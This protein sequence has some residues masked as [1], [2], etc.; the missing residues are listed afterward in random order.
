MMLNNFTHLTSLIKIDDKQLLLIVILFVDILNFS[1]PFGSIN[2]TPIRRLEI[3][4][5][6]A[7]PLSHL[8]YTVP[9]INTAIITGWQLTRLNILHGMLGVISHK[10]GNLVVVWHQLCVY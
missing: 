5:N 6:V 4:I 3:I 10:V 8:I 1:L 7:A 2:F 9:L